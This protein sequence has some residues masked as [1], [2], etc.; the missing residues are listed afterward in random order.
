MAADAQ[1]SSVP[2][3][4]LC[5]RL[6]VL[7]HLTLLRVTWGAGSEGEE[8]ASKM[9]KIKISANQPVVLVTTGQL[10]KHH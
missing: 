9:K 4:L 1:S 8:M 10:I 5:N 7:I 6:E 3:R 2:R